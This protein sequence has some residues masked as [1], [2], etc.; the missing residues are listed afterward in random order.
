VE[1]IGIEEGGRLG[2]VPSLREK[3]DRSSRA[4]PE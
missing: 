3:A 2:T 4:W 1:L